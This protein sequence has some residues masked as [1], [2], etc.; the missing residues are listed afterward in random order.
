MAIACARTTNVALTHGRPRGRLRIAEE[1]AR[2]SSAAE[3]LYEAEE[4]LKASES[5]LNKCA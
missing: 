2:Q 4:R 5:L 1:N 3:Q